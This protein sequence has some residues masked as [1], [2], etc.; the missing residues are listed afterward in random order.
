MQWSWP[1]KHAYTGTPV[2]T[3]KQTE[4][5]QHFPTRHFVLAFAWAVL[6]NR[7]LALT[8]K[9]NTGM[10]CP[11]GT[12]AG[13]VEL[14]VQV[15]DASALFLASRQRRRAFQSDETST[16]KAHVG[17]L[18][19]SCVLAALAMLF[20]LAV[21][22]PLATSSLREIAA[23]SAFRGLVVRNLFLNSLVA[24]GVLLSGLYLLAY[25]APTTL[26]LIG[27]ATLTAT[28]YTSQPITGYGVAYPIPAIAV[29]LGLFAVICLAFLARDTIRLDTEDWPF[30]S[31][32]KPQH[33]KRLTM[34]FIIITLFLAANL[35]RSTFSQPLDPIS[36][37]E[38]GQLASD[39]WI[40]HAGT[41]HS[42]R[43]AAVVYKARYGLPPPPKFDEWF[44]FAVAHNSPIIDI[45]DQIHSDLKPFWG[46]T[47]AEL[48]SRTSHLLAQT[49]LGL[50]GLRIRGGSVEM[51]PNTQPTHRWMVE[52]WKAMIE[53]FAAKLPD[54]D[55]VFNLDDECRV[56]I[57]AHDLAKLSS[58]PEA[59][60]YPLRKLFSKAA[61][62]PWD[63]DAF[64]H[65]ET[66]RSE[67]FNE[68]DPK[69]GV[70]D[71]W[72]APT[73][74]PNSAALRYR[75]WDGNRA[76]AEARG[77]VIASVPDLCNRPD[78]AQ[79]HGF[80]L[81]PRSGLAITQHAMPI[82]SQSRAGG[83][84]DILV[85]SPWNFVDKVA[86]DDI[87]DIEWE[88]KA[89]TIFW[90][91]S[92]SDG[93]AGN[94]WPG[95]MRARAVNLAKTARP[96]LS[97]RIDAPAV[98]ISF[99]GKFTRCD[100]TYCQSMASTFYGHDGT[101][102]DP[103]TVDFQDHWLHRH[104]IDFDGVGFS[105]RFL[106]FLQSKSTVYRATLFRTWMDERTHPWK[107]YVPLDVSLSGIWDVIWLVSKYIVV[108]TES[109]T[110]VPLAQHIAGEG[111][112]W[113]AKALRKEDMQVY[114]F[115][116]LLEWGRLVDDN[117]EE[118]GYAP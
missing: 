48:R 4:L 78:L 58:T 76:M 61:D 102:Q 17:R 3:K 9:P 47:P 24:A 103:P 18:A 12:A 92:S 87:K 104:L 96:G 69:L 35:T 13:L 93:F 43:E 118:L 51:G 26:A 8:T 5:R 86:V 15:F 105:G 72:I 82:F 109:E 88:T 39:D 11:T 33:Q 36:I 46:L 27:V 60:S 90:R 81:S 25:L 37:I 63:D 52:A 55:L 50:G 1:N 7:L 21:T 89:D 112:N 114:M 20:A 79:M 110:P 22:S 10:V 107:H 117:R 40:N 98:D 44:S 62:P 116:L 28:L 71:E 113:A 80:L 57:P 23:T 59:D 42:A 83:F 31:A 100:Q 115:R 91:G 32:E 14:L 66:R 49:G 30:S 16:S 29:I 41:S 101:A 65:G 54:M 95:F 106:P 19:V 111:R 53:P 77:G 6:A 73:C 45:F 75:W 68:K 56:A 99:T 74:P 2:T 38:N 67:Y 70:F 84:N 97:T 94:T 34:C 64:E 85:P 108:S